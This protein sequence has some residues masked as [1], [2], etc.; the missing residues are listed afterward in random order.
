M[1]AIEATRVA[2]KL[3]DCVGFRVSADS[4]TDAGI[5]PGDLVVVDLDRPA[6]EG[7]LVAVALSNGT[8][9][10]LEWRP[11]F[12]LPRGGLMAT[13]RA[14]DPAIRI[15]GVCVQLQRDLVL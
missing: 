1:S 8:G 13:L 5:R 9:A 11:P 14:D 2:A 7:S 10:V 15:V 6:K 12:L 3:G 4:A